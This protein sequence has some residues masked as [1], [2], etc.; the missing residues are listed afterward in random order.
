M[1]RTKRQTRTYT[2]EDL[3][4]IRDKI[5]VH[6]CVTAAELRDGYQR[7]ISSGNWEHVAKL[8]DSAQ[9][10]C[11]FRVALMGI[12]TLIQLADGGR[13]VDPREYLSGCGLDADGSD[14]SGHIP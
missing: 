12:D 11:S 10:I 3:R 4:D 14:I 13:D 7:C 5:V 2:A 9:R 8:R 6:R 1:A